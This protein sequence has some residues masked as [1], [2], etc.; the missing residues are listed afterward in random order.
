[1]SPVDRRTFLKGTL[2]AAGAVAVTGLPWV[3][4]RP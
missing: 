1:M 2:G 4:G 3:R